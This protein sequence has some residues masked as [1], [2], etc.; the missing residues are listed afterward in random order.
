MLYLPNFRT[1]GLPIK[2][3]LGAELKE[4]CE[5]LRQKSLLSLKRLFKP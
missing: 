3:D 5:Q 2:S 1:D 4:S